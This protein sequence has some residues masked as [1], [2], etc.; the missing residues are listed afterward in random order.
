MT[1]I[2]VQNSCVFRNDSASEAQSYLE[3]QDGRVVSKLAI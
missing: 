2:L 3:S 1:V